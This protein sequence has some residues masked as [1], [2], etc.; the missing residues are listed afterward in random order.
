MRIQTVAVALVV[1]SV[2]LNCG[3]AARSY[4]DRTPVELFFAGNTTLFEQSVGLL[5]DALDSNKVQSCRG[6]PQIPLRNSAF[7][8]EQNRRVTT[9]AMISCACTIPLRADERTPQNCSASTTLTV[10]FFFGGA[11][12]P[13]TSC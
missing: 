7:L 4:E 1:A 11:A 3:A 9:R 5:Y 6:V 2:Q 10:T 13:R 12:G 8:R